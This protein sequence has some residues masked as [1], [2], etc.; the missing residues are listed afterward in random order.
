MMQGSSRQQKHA[1]GSIGLC[2]TSGHLPPVWVTPGVLA[3]S[4]MLLHLRTTNSLRFQNTTMS[5][6]VEDSPALPGSYPQS[7]P[8]IDPDSAPDCSHSCP[9]C[10]CL[11]LDALDVNT[12]VAR[13][14][15]QIQRFARLVRFVQPSSDTSERVATN[16][17]DVSST[18]DKIDK[19]LSRTSAKLGRLG[20]VLESRLD[21][22]ES[23]VTDKVEWCL[24]G[25]LTG[26]Q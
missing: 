25:D 16:L 18:K 2:T 23:A 21:D 5:D 15:Q 13:A 12:P 7:P 1:Q 20:S 26:K 9:P 11:E 22:L 6:P 3:I 19:L 8:P 14:Q 10:I 4:A 17:T 24:E